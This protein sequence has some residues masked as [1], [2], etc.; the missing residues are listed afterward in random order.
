M[1]QSIEP[2]TTVIQAA[3]NYGRFAIAPLPAGYGPLL[4]NALR[5][6]L[7]T[8][9]PGAAITKV[10][11]ERVPHEFGTIPGV[12]EDVTELV[13]NLKG[14]R[15]RSY[16]DRAVRMLLVAKGQHIVR[17]ADI[18][19]PSTVE[20]ANPNH[21]LCTMDDENADLTMELTVERGRGSLLADG[22]EVGAIG[23]I[24]IDAI[25]TP[26]VKVNYVVERDSDLAGEPERLLLEIWTDGT[27][28]AGD[29]LS[30]AAQILVQYFDSF[31]AWGQ[32]EPAAAAELA[33]SPKQIPDE[34][35]NIPIDELELSTRTFNALRRADITKVGQLLTM[36]ERALMSV[37]NLGR[38]SID[39][40]RERL[41]ARGF[42]T[43][44]R[45]AMVD[46]EQ[47]GSDGA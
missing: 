15:L 18:E 47:N 37:R 2:T 32:P 20:I 45:G 34:I 24:A 28:K 29:A 6:V 39:E 27:I 41:A 5:R 16:A 14:V 46:S 10:K 25:F 22:R 38:A 30:H 12:R 43:E 7:I 3:E 23:E 31:A 19:A 17:A 21:Y 42:V 4:G 26:I 36:D 40:I 1:L 9:I 33:A 44:S 11:I 8:S 13:L 35:A